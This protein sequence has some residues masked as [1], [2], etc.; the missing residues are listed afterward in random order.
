MIAA[1]K[2]WYAVWAALLWVSP[3]ASAA[4]DLAGAARELARKTAALAGRGEPVTVSWRNLSSLGSRD[5][6]QARGWFETALRE[7]G[8]RVVET[9]PTVEA[10]L[11]LSENQSQYLLVEE[12]H[13]GDERQV[14]ISS[15]RRAVPAA[16]APAQTLALARKLV[17]EQPEP[18]LDIAFPPAAMLVLSPLRITRYAQQSAQWEPRESAAISPAHPWPRDLRGR[19]RVTG[20]SFGAYLPGM[21]CNGS[22]SA[23]L[24]L[25]CKPSDEPW[26]LESGGR[27]L[28]LASFAL[29]RNY[30]D[31]R[32]VTQAGVRKTVAPFYS[33]A[34]FEDQGRAVWLLALVDGRTQILDAAL[35]PTGAF[36]AAW[37][38]DIAGAAGRCGG[39]SQILASRPTDSADADAV[40]AFAVASGAPAP[41][42]APVEFPGPV[43]AL[44]P[45]GADSVLAVVHDSTS[46]KYLA[47]LLT[48]T[49]GE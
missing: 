27:L 48:V 30:F 10:H 11:T 43:T 25:D 31:G 24:T 37:G 3:G 35:E 6:E 19:V 7:S 9:T 14:W 4:D 41:V 23:Q 29:E 21:A 18:I 1:V 46:G 2:G 47:Y 17:W 32:V 20:Q 40:Q 42:T 33:A 5:L 8:A 36:N 39:G 28:L 45:S 13:K 22:V 44:W 34:A 15:W 26:V 16:S 12:A 38:S 49:C